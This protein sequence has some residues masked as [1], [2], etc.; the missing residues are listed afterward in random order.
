M[1]SYKYLYRAIVHLV[2]QLHETHNSTALCS[3][4]YVGVLLNVV[5]LLFGSSQ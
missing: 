1:V 3:I 2:V 5:F 4:H